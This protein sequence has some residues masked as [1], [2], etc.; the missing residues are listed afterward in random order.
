M[1][2]IFKQ[3]HWFLFQNYRHFANINLFCFHHAGGAASFFIDWQKH[4]PALAQ[5][6][7]IQLPGRES[8]YSEPFL[9]DI[10]L[11]VDKII[12]NEKVFIQKPCVFFGHSFGALIAFELSR[13][14]QSKK[15]SQLK[16][17][18]VS[19]HCAPRF[20]A[21]REKLHALPDDEF[22]ERIKEK[23][24]GLSHEILSCPELLSLI[25][26]RLRADIYAS[27]NYSYSKTTPLDC[28]V[29]VFNGAKDLSIDRDK[30][31]AWGEE[32]TNS[33]K[34]YGFSG[35]HF[36]VNNEKKEVLARINKILTA[37]EYQ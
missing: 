32:T 23:Y 16:G 14:L 19:G 13:Q 4:L 10:G 34:L 26:P 5:L 7:A 25:L 36:F 21:E 20:L 2:K 3:N 6:I 29:F 31:F 24:G 35:D 30:L 12:E 33:M 28:P 1:E 27:E 9:S 18:I 22:L 8:R 11:I 15:L 37:L 17:L